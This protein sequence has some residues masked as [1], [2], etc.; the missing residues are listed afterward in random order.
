MKTITLTCDAI[1]A[2]PAGEELDALVAKK[3]MGWSAE[4]VQLAKYRL[5]GVLWACS[6][7]AVKGI[8]DLPRYSTDIAAAWE[9][10]LVVSERHKAPIF[11]IHR[12]GPK[13]FLADLHGEE[14]LVVS[15]ETMPLA[16]C[17]AALMLTVQE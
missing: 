5:L 12:A 15:A 14:T 7:C 13:K 11:S 9:V 6:E 10:A 2:M 16:V 8:P 1:L 17:R 4:H 3:V